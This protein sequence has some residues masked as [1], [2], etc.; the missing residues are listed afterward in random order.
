MVFN[1]FSEL[2]QAFLALVGLLSLR[3]QQVQSYAGSQSLPVLMQDLLNCLVL[4]E[5]AYKV[6]DMGKK[7]ATETINRIRQTFP[8]GAMTAKHVQWSLPSVFHRCKFPSLRS[9]HLLDIKAGNISW[10]NDLTA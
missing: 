3:L 5:C 9:S 8:E 2:V 4:A 10:G 6:V 7:K 1:Y